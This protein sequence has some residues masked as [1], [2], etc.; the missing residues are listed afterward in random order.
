MLS[1]NRYCHEYRRINNR[2]L[3]GLFSAKFV[4]EFFWLVGWG[5]IGKMVSQNNVDYSNLDNRYNPGSSSCTAFTL[6]TLP[7]CL[8]AAS[9][10]NANTD[11]ATIQ[12]NEVICNYDNH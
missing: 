7:P 12:H 3:G 9:L 10:S 5:E 11:F 6:G 2:G 8:A 1:K 4:F